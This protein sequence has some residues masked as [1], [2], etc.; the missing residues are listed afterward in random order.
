MAVEHQ[1]SYAMRIKH[2]AQS[3][4][5]MTFVMIAICLLAFG[6]VRIFR[7]IGMDLAERRWSHENTIT[8]GNDVQV[9][10]NPDFYRTKRMNSAVK[11]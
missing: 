3:T 2:K 9:Q 7:F 10:L 8:T 5:E 11:Y 6:M 1:G 4:I